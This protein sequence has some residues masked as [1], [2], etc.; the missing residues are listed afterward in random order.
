MTKIKKQTEALISSIFVF[1]LT[2]I[3]VRVEEPF[4]GLIAA[5]IVWLYFWANSE[6]K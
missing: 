3:G 1:G 4:L 5:I 6:D 2:V